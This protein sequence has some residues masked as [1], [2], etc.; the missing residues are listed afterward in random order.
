[1]HLIDLIP[2]RTPLVVGQKLEPIT[3]LKWLTQLVTVV[4]RTPQVLGS[5]ALTA[6]AASVGTTDI[7]LVGE[8]HAGLA[9]LTYALRITR[10][11]G[12][13][14]SAQ[15]TFNWTDGGVGQTM[16]FTA[17]TG[18][19]TTTTQGEMLPFHTDAGAVPSYSVAYGSVGAPT[20]QFSFSLAIEAMP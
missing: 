18:N 16:V 4:N 5:V 11:A 17:V 9:R 1:M 7:P 13:S 3:W 12:T 20:M 2:F 15:V 19:T 8:L 6:Q 10:A 14:S